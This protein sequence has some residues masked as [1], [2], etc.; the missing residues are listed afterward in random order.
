[1]AKYKK[2]YIS[3][4]MYKTRLA[5]FT[6]NMIKISKHTDKSYALGVTKF[7]DLTNEE[8]KINYT[9]LIP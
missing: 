9:S 7:A 4:D 8:F 6:D 5:A 1:M 2:S 3:S